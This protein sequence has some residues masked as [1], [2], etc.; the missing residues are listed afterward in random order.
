MS[1]LTSSVFSLSH[2]AAKIMPCMILLFAFFGFSESLGAES[3]R[4][5]GHRNQWQLEDIAVFRNEFLAIDR[6]FTPEARKQALR[7]LSRLEE[8]A[9]GPEE[10]AVELCRIAALADNGH[11]QCLPNWL[12]RDICQWVVAIGFV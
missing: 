11:T 4:T 3:A 10:F 2:C 6:A 7:R 5:S 9:L 8:Q 12:G 1:V